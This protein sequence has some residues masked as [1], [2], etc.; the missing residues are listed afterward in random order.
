MQYY[1]EITLSPKDLN[2]ASDIANL[3]VESVGHQ[4]KS[5]VSCGYH[6]ALLPKVWRASIPKTMVEKH[7]RHVK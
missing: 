3:L 2:A 7:N 6:F 5:R 1:T 4:L